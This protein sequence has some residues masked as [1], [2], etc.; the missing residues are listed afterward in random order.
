MIRA[1]KLSFPA[2]QGLV[3]EHT[4]HVQFATFHNHLLPI[5]APV[6]ATPL[7]VNTSILS[8]LLKT[9]MAKREVRSITYHMK[10]AR[11]PV[12]QAN[13]KELEAVIAIARWGT[14]RAATVD[15]GM[16][17]TA[18]SHTIGRLQAGLDVRLPLQ[19][20]LEVKDLRSSHPVCRS[21]CVLGERDSSST[22]LFRSRCPSRVGL[23]VIPYAINERVGIEPAGA[24][25]CGLQHVSTCEN[26]SGFIRWSA[27]YAR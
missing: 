3:S 22:A 6:V 15:L 27:C 8:Q 2:V 17:T 23:A 19:A 24:C 14:F 11:F 18:L 13:L 7:P 12:E 1:G 20:A 9:E 5:V 26:L 25:T 21:P 4:C 16:S 10:A